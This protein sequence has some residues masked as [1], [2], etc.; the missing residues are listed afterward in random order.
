MTLFE[1]YKG[2]NCNCVSNWTLQLD[3]LVNSKLKCVYKYLA[4]HRFNFSIKFRKKLVNASR[5]TCFFASLWEK[6]GP[7][8]FS[9]VP[10]YQQIIFLNCRDLYLVFPDNRT[11]VNV[12]PRQWYPNCIGGV[13]YIRGYCIQDVA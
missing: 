13:Y 7:W 8:F 4:L 1:K 9:L 10:F 3:F 5:I 12:E 2:A 6:R 11:T